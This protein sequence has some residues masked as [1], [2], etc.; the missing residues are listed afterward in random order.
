MVDR[1]VDYCETRLLWDEFL[2]EVAKD[3]PGQHRRFA[4]NLTPKEPE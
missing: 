2:A 4:S 3:N 1:V